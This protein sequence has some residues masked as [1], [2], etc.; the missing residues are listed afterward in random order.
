MRIGSPHLQYYLALRVLAVI[1]KKKNLAVVSRPHHIYNARL[2]DHANGPIIRSAIARAPVLILVAWGS[3]PQCNH[4][5]SQSEVT[6]S[7]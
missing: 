1:L 5:L 7:M 6:C 2:G 4:G 3:L